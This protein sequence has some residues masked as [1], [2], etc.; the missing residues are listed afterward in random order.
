MDAGM[1]GRLF[2]LAIRAATVAALAGGAGAA[3]ANG[4]DCRGA[5]AVCSVEGGTYHIV[6]PEGAGAAPVPAVMFLHGYNANGRAMLNSGRV[7]PPLLARGYAVIAPNGRDRDGSD[8]GRWSFIPGRPELRDEA[9]FLQRVKADVVARHGIDGE[10]IL[11]GGYSIGG[12]MAS[13]IACA[14]PQAFAAYF[15]VAGGF[16]RPHPEACAGPVRLHHTHGWRD[17]TVP[18]EG[19]P[20]GGGEIVQG[21]IFHTML[22]WRRAN[23]CTGMRADSFETGAGFWQRGWTECE[24]GA[25]RLVLH[26]G[27]HRV[28][29][30]WA[31]LAVDW[32]EA[33]P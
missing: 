4:A 2:R 20:L 7:T 11:L 30:G 22:L 5:E 3:A 33:L 23:G 1:G 27:G 32:F 26:P 17:S 13:Y 12:S 16:W 6:L 15:P 19:R 24:G 18:L 9:A 28:P 25:L 14:T 8:G 10:R 21:D 31:G 29:Q